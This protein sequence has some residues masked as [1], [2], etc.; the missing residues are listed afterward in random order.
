[1]DT[2]DRELIQLAI[3]WAPFGGAP[4]QEIFESFGM[5]LERFHRIV[6][7]ALSSIGAG[8][9]AQLEPL[10]GHLPLHWGPEEIAD[11]LTGSQAAVRSSQ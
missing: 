7:E 9:D 5:N 4:E 3:R 8:T 10:I 2:F 1:M 6:R 11:Y